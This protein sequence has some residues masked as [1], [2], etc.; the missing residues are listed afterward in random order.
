MP[1]TV[2]QVC[3]VKMVPISGYKP[4]EG[5]E[6]VL[7]GTIEVILRPVP[8]A[9]IVIPYRVTVPTIIGAA[10]LTSVQADITMPDQQRIAMRH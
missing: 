8:L 1:P 10:V 2:D 5:S 4:G 7:N 6:S 9:N 3:H